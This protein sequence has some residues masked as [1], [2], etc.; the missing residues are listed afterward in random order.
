MKTLVS[1]YDY[2]N[3]SYAFE[4]VFDGETAFDRVCS[5]IKKLL[6]NDSCGKVGGVVV[7]T[8]QEHKE[9]IVRAVDGFPVPVDVVVEDCE[10]VSAF[11]G[12]LAKKSEGFDSIIHAESCCPFYDADLTKEICCLHMDSAAEYTFAE[13]WPEGL[14]PCVVNPGTVSILSSIGKRSGGKK[15]EKNVFF[16]AMKSDI[17]S[18]EIETLMAPEDMRLYRLDFSCVTKEKQLVCVNLFNLIGGSS[19]KSKDFAASNLASK[20]VFAPCVLRTVPAFYNVQVSSVCPGTCN[21]CPYPKESKRCFGHDP[22][23]AEQENPN[24]FMPLEKVEKL[25]SAAADFSCEAVI[26]LS[27]WGEPLYHPD[28]AGCVAAVLRYEGL[29]VLLETDGML[30]TSELVD[31]ISSLGK[32]AKPRTNGYPP[33][34][35]IVSLDSVDESGYKA[36]RGEGCSGSPISFDKACKA[37]D[38]LNS[39]FPGAV[40]AQFLRT[41]LNEMQLEQ[42]YRSRKDSGMIIQKYDDFA[43]LLP[44]YKVTDLSPVIRNPCWHQRRDMVVLVDGSVP[45]CREFMLAGNLGNVFD[46]SLPSVWEKGKDMVFTDKCGKCDEYYTFN[47]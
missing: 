6:D 47:F 8:C 36:M 18:F 1:V 38:L 33:V 27:L 12:L 32:T 31:K 23:V 16:E 14:A 9:S 39:A 46:E 41:K 45:V 40:Y 28:I 20:A 17:N 42:F 26:S 11:L 24:C 29:S 19:A 7:F 5:W 22:C 2:K 13:G 21:F 35:W 30:V 44:D 25:A 15:V 43:G 34:I 10:E 37:F 4:P 3:H